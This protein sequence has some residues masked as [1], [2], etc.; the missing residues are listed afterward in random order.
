MLKFFKWQ[1]SQ[2]LESYRVGWGAVRWADNMAVIYWLFNKTGETWLLD[3][4]GKIHENSV[5][6]TT[7]IP[8]WHNVNLAQG[9][10]EPAE[11]WMQARETRFLYATESS[12]EKIMGTWGQFPGGGFAGD[13]NVRKTYRDPRQGFETC[14]SRSSC[15][16][17]R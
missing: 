3:L 10:R 9:I 5:N 11:Y 15:T 7:D 16:P 13:E 12:Y 4:A 8:T 14:A 6:Y 1:D 2:K 17:S